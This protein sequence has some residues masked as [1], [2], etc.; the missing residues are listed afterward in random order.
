MSQ[1]DRVYLYDTTLRD[2]AQTMGV[3]FSAADKAA[4]ARELDALGI[5]Y[6]EG[7]WPGANP[8]DDAF[9]A[10]LPDLSRARLAAFGMTR[11]A[12]RSAANDPGLSAV[13]GVGAPVVTLVGKTW[14]FQCKVA[15]GID[16]DENRRMVADSVAH[17]TTR[18]GEVMFDAEH[19]FDGYRDNAAYALSCLEAAL[20]AGARWV[21]LCDTNGGTLPE[22]V[23]RMVGEVTARLPGDR[24]GIHCHNDTA[25][26]VASS[27][28]AVRAGARQVQGTVNGLGER[29]GNADLIAIIPSLMLKMGFETGLAGPDLARLTQVSRKF[30]ERLNRA[31]N[32]HA[33]YV[34]E[35]A[36]A[37]KGGLHV[38]AVEK[39][40]RCYEHIIPDLVGNRR[41]ILVSDQ[42]GRSNVLSRFREIGIEVEPDNPK[43][44]HLLE[45]V[46]LREFNGYAYD[47]AE[48]S[49]E[50][51]AREVLDEVPVFFSLN[52]FRVIDERRWNAKGELITLS[53]ATVKATIHGQQTMTVAEGNGPVSALDTALRKILIPVYPTIAGLKLVDYKVRILNPD[54]ATNAVTRV[55]IESADDRGG[56]WTTVGVSS[57]VIDASYIALRDSVIFKLM[58]DGETGE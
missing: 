50:L 44:A 32:R 49:F 40:P 56:R 24:V 18:A 10:A 17:A 45:E 2:G 47:G 25:T 54:A 1:S 13:L 30:D 22:E 12:G 39:D 6:I 11:R 43:I 53:E 38:S 28:A 55:L 58:R 48:A 33:A 16:P 14:D 51:L 3:D 31:P 20:E 26:A 15:L 29:C 5:D 7:G 4:I 46:K 57:N 23:E 21:V 8:T 36:F 52:S 19:F 27:L 34:G 35:S 9:F 37:H 41:Q 42:S